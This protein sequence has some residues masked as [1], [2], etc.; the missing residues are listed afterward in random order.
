MLG[1]RLI[2]TALKSDERL[3]FGEVPSTVGRLLVIIAVL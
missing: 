1:E 3:S 2:L